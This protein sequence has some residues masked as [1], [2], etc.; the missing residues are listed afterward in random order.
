WLMRQ[1]GRY[2]PEYRELRRR[3]SFME[4]C[5]SPEISAELTIL[6]V[7]KFGVDGAIIFSDILTP[8]E[9]CGFDVRIEEGGGGVAVENLKTEKDIEKLRSYTPDSTSFVYESIRIVKKML[10]GKVPVIGFAGA[11]FTLA[12]YLVE[13]GTTRNML[14]VKQLMYSN[15]GLWNR[16][17]DSLTDVVLHHSREQ[18]RAGADVIQLFD[19]WVGVLSPLDYRKYVM[20]YMKRLVREIKTAGC[21]VIHFA[22]CSAG[23][24]KLMQEAGGDVI[25]IDWRIDI[26]H[27]WE[28]IGD[29]TGI[30]G[31]LDPAKLLADKRLIEEEARSILDKT[32]SRPGYIFNLGHG[33]L[34]NTPCENVKFLVEY[35]HSY[36]VDVA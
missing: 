27:A 26:G 9:A 13:G 25:G 22:T 28:V 29:K 17:M 7:E 21:Y 1:V 34:P 19:S 15:A 23:I 24:L 14:S 31:N 32:G 11:P 6:P 4:I 2:L 36:E 8:I 30:Q 16:L 20:P 5:K 3:M 18:V 35:V 12:C 33:V 10:N